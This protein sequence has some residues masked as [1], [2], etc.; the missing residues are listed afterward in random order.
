MD[1]EG[2]SALRSTAPIDAYGLTGV[3]ARGTSNHVSQLLPTFSWRSPT[4]LMLRAPGEGRPRA[5][6]GGQHSFFFL[7]QCLKDMDEGHVAVAKLQPS[8]HIFAALG[9]GQVQEAS[10]FGGGWCQSLLIR[11]CC[12]AGIVEPKTINTDANVV[13]GGSVLPRPE[14]GVHSAI[15]A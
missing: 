12:A 7:A 13:A 4:H 2:D 14:V 8:Q 6:R 1:A 3:I 10:A 9:C 15:L 11:T 5:L